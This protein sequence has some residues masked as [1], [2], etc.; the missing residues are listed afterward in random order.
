MKFKTVTVLVL[1][2][3]A[4]ALSLVLIGCNNPAAQTK[5][6]ADEIAYT[7]NA[8]AI[9]Q[10]VTT[11]RSATEQLA[12]SDKAAAVSV[13]SADGAVVAVKTEK[14]DARLDTAHTDLISATKSL[15]AADLQTS[16]II[17]A[18][19]KT[20][21]DLTTHITADD[22]LLS[23]AKA[24]AQKT[25]NALNAKEA[26]KKRA[27]DLQAFKDAHKNDFWGEGVHRFFRALS[28]TLLITLAVLAIAIGVLGAIYGLPKI[29]NP[30]LTFADSA[31][32]WVRVA[33]HYVYKWI[34]TAIPIAGHQIYV[35]F[36]ELKIFRQSATVVKVA[37][38]TPTPSPVAGAAPP[39][40][41]LIAA[42]RR[43]GVA[44]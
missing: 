43:R 35:W 38:P 42:L 10:A 25:A 6:V 29:T 17:A 24:E 3:M 19:T 26:E 16:A 4:V 18:Q 37:V 5:H 23:Q 28:W 41:E 40:L 22:A 33:L 30:A 27:D 11:Q 31:L 13:A 7:S 1:A 36:E 15:T 8:P 12:A 34:V 9:E 21:T 39:S 20:I 32:N 44:V 2:F 14:P